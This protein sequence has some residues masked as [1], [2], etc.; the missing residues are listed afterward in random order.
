MQHD[1]P[2]SSSCSTIFLRL[3]MN[4]AES[5]IDFHRLYLS[6]YQGTAPATFL[7][8]AIASNSP[9]VPYGHRSFYQISLFTGGQARL[10]YGGEIIAINGPALVLLNPLVAYAQTCPTQAP[11]TGFFCLFTTDFLH[12]PGYA[13]S[14]QESALLRFD[15]PPV[16]VLTEAQGAFL[17]QLFQ[18]VLAEATSTYRYRDDLLRTYV[19][20]LLHEAQRL[21]PEL[22]SCP[23]SRAHHRL[24][25]QFMQ[26]LEA[27]FPIAS[28]SQPL[29]L[30]TAEALAGHLGV[31][32]NYLNRV[33]RQ[34][35][36]RTTSSYVAAR[37][38]QEAKALLLHTDWAVAD[39]SDS[40]RFA[41][42]TYFAHFFRKHVGVSANT[43]RQQ[44]IRNLDGIV[45]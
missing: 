39:I 36:G 26:A 12:R 19:Q 5:L 33:L 34:V 35:T 4:I 24:V 2:K 25:A 37:I 9:S 18:Q 32:V 44:T 27:Q 38:T 30:H 3:S 40:L 28:T 45:R 16:T 13:A 31:H 21:R 15:V 6:R 42:P 8:H 41:D 10:D 23:A 20:L 1:F 7:T 22:Q 43:F 29:R 11:L 14:V 17:S